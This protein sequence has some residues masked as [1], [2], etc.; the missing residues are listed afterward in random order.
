MKFFPAGLAV[1]LAASSVS[2]VEMPAFFSD[3]MVLQREA[4]V[5]LWGTGTPGEVVRVEFQ[6]QKLSATVDDSGNWSV[7]LK[8]MPADRKPG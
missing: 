1:L 3:N 4:Q 8:P 2:A 7:K 5:P 6:S